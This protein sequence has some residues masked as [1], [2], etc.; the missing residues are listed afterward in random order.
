MEVA[1]RGSTFYRSG[2]FLLAKEKQRNGL[3]SGKQREMIVFSDT[4]IT[5]SV[6]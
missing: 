6:L 4:I 5:H 2:F 3:H 1:S